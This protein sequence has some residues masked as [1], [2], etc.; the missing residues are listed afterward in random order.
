MPIRIRLSLLA[1]GDSMIQIVDGFLASRLQG[2]AV[3]VH[4]DARI[5]T[6]ITKPCIS[7]LPA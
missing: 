5:S 6:G 1:T 4:T 3:G 7:F 2:A